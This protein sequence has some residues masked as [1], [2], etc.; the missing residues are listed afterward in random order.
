MGGRWELTSFCVLRPFFDC[1][2]PAK[3]S[4]SASTATVPVLSCC[5]PPRILSD[6]RAI[7]DISDALKNGMGTVLPA[8]YIEKSCKTVNNR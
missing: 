8:A 2:S 1:P 4:C 3:S 6:K 7:G 5:M